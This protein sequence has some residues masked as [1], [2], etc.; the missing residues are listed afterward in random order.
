MSSPCGCGSGL[1]WPANSARARVSAVTSATVPCRV[2]R[3]TASTRVAPASAAMTGTGI[4]PCRRLRQHHRSVNCR[5]RSSTARRA[6]RA[7][8]CGRMPGRWRAMRC[9]ASTQCLV[10][11]SPRTER[12]VPVIAP[13]DGIMRSRMAN[14][15]E[16]DGAARGNRC[17]RPY[18][19]CAQPGRGRSAGGGRRGSVG[20]GGAGPRVAAFEEAFATR[21]GAVSGVGVSSCTAGLHLALRPRARAR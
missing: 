14:R 17:P 18:L 3:V 19:S 5:P 8:R 7:S 6:S 15:R 16:G 1:Q 11:M 2:V 4:S 21:V 9:V 12:P 20:L 10:A 13:G